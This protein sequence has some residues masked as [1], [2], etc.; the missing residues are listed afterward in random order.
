MDIGL[1]IHEL[2]VEGGGERQCVCLAQ[3][4]ARHGHTVTLYTSAY[5]RPNCFP[6]ICKS[7]TIEEVGRGPLPWLRKP[8][9]LRGYLDMLRL[10][11][12]VE[13][14]RQILNP[15]HWPAQWA[16]VWVKRKLGGKVVWMC[17]D[18]PD[19]Q[20]KARRLQSVQS[21]ILAPLYWVYYLYDR[22]QN[23][24]VDLT[25]LLSNWA[26]SEYQAFYC[27][28]TRV[29]RSGADPTRFAPGGD[30]IRIRARF[31]FADDEFILLWLGIFMP[32]RRLEDA[33]EAVGHLASQGTKVRL[34]LAGSDR[35]YPEYLSSLKAL[36]HGLGLQHVVTFAGKVADD[37]ICDFYAACDAF[38]FP[39]DQQ[40][41]GLVVLEA[42]ACGCPVLVSQGAGV[43][44]VLIDGENA[45]LFPPRNPQALAEKIEALAGGP[46]LR[47]KIAQSGMQ[48]ARDTYNWDRF[49]DQI[50]RVCQEVFQ[51]DGSEVLLSASAASVRPL[52][53]S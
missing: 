52:T 37:E 43:H 11:T 53:R 50:C 47:R 36:A 41:W 4:L 8:L 28:P 20:Q 19:F 16:A 12:K 45:M 30:R 13:A 38:V 44:E 35:S 42:M 10:S 14:S 21:A 7:F 22:R 32:H 31:G 26:E 1:I 29:V 6:E 49:A 23:R 2:L 25:L 34:L 33:I 39:N 24:E 17:N 46:Q 48:L 51:S 40:T 18:V 3:A 27:G 9:F 15:H 5:D